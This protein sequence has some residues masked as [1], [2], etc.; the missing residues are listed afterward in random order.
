MLYCSILVSNASAVVFYSTSDTTHN[1]TAPTGTLANSGWQWVGYW[2]NFQGAPIDAHHFL[3]ANHVGGSVGDTFVY[4]GLNYTTVN[5]YADSSSDLRIWEVREAF[6]SWATLYR[7]TNEVGRTLMVFGRGVTRGSEVRT[8]VAVSGVPV[9][10]LAG[11]QWGNYDGVLRWGQNTVTGTTT[12]PTFGPQLAATFDKTGGSNEC[13]LGLYDSSA[14]VFVND[15]S[16]WKLAGIAGLVDGGFST[17]SA[18]AG[19]SAFI[20]D[21][22]GLYVGGSGPI[23]AA[24]AVPSSFYATRVS[25]RTSWIDGILALPLTATVTLVNLEQVYDGAAKTIGVTTF[26]ADL[27]YSVT[28]DGASTPPVSVG[29]YAV[30]VTVTSAGYSGTASGTLVVSAPANNVDASD[31]PAMPPW[32]IALL[33][34]MIILTSHN[35]LHPNFQQGAHKTSS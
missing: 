13:H 31:V 16:S 5:T 32:A 23:T 1:T 15:G 26:P 3:A 7:N 6:P 21:A 30:M 25:S 35:R 20:F 9:G 24:I 27:S 11:W 34:A 10:S 12:H 2:G 28:Y 29:S 22:R 19:F 33:A 4:Q 17:T 8:T 14:P 18:E